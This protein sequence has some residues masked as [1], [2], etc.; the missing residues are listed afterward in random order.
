VDDAYANVET[1]P[2]ITN[3]YLSM[4]RSPEPA[5][6]QTLDL[7]ADIVERVETRVGHTEFES[8]GAYVAWVM[9]EVLA[10]VET[11]EG[12]FSA[13]DEAQVKDKLESLGY[14]NG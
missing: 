11:G 14:L 4:S 13:A 3:S 5:E 7:P 2:E 9:E 12:E 1:T 10:E 8:A 6:T